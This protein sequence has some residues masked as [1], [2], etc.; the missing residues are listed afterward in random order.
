MSGC[1]VPS[2][3]M[4][5][6]PKMGVQRASRSYWASLAGCTGQGGGMRPGLTSAFSPSV[7]RCLGAARRAGVNDLAG[8]RDVPR[9]AHRLVDACEQTLDGA[10]VGRSFAEKPDRL[11]VGCPVGEVQPEKTREPQPVVDEELGAIV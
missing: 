2:S 9:L 7:L 5:A 11:R 6:L 1:R 10:G 3:R 8:Q 4:R